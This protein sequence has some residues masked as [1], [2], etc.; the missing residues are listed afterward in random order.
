MQEERQ[1]QEEGDGGP[2]QPGRPAHLACITLAPLEE[3]FVEV[4]LALVEVVYEVA[5]PG[6]V[7]QQ[8]QQK[9]QSGA[10]QHSRPGSANTMR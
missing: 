6:E 9:E 1:P 2:G 7:E 10:P 4:T 8:Q 5:G 3:S